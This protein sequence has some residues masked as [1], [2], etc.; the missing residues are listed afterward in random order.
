MLKYGFFDSVK[1]DRKYNVRDIATLFDGIIVDGIYAQI[2][3]RFS[4]N[5][6]TTIENAEDD[7]TVAVGTGQ[8]WLNH[9][10]IINTTPLY[11][12]FDAPNGRFDA[13]VLEVNEKDRNASIFIKK[14][15]ETK[16]GTTTPSIKDNQLTNTDEI[17]QHLLALVHLRSG[18]STITQ[19][20]ITSKIG[21][22][23]PDGIPYVTSP[24]K[25][26]PADETLKQWVAQWS[27][28]YN[29]AIA[30]LET[31]QDDFDTFMTESGEAFTTAQNGRET[32]FNAAQE[33]RSEI[34]SESE[35]S[36]TDIFNTKQTERATAFT[37]QLETQQDDFDTAQNQKQNAFNA[38][39]NTIA[40][41]LISSE[42][43]W[44]TWFENTENAWD[45]WFA[46]VQSSAVTEAY[47]NQI[48]DGKIAE[49][50][51]TAPENLDTI[52]ELAEA[53]Q[54][55]D[56]VLKILNQSIATKATTTY[57]NAQLSTK[58]DNTRFG[59]SQDGLAPAGGS[60]YASFMG[61]G[62]PRFLN[63]DGVYQKIDIVSKY[64]DGLVPK[65]PD[66]DT[67]TKFLRQDGIWDIPGE[68]SY[69]PL[70]GGTLMG[71]LIIGDPNHLD[72][73]TK[74]YALSDYSSS[75]YSQIRLSRNQINYNVVKIFPP[76]SIKKYIT[77]SDNVYLMGT[78]YEAEQ[79]STSEEINYYNVESSG[80]ILN[81]INFSMYEQPKIFLVVTICATIN[82][83]SSLTTDV[84]VYDISYFIPYIN[85]DLNLVKYVRKQVGSNG[86]LRFSYTITNANDDQDGTI[87]L[88][89]NAL[90]YVYSRA[91]ILN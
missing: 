72:N 88:N 89:I 90:T 48:V 70:T 78:A 73:K 65:L 83:S 75:Y 49:L 2:G 57:V 62:I 22:D 25:S 82:A 54:E 79:L 8:A 13:I 68:G 71:S 19:A 46:T 43:D 87:N 26:F 63:V 7:I 33:S 58:A 40:E 67:T 1:G 36:R 81:F 41:W 85:K 66:E 50:V 4:V 91:F 20:D 39:V 3:D 56:D 51:G 74:I 37:E 86:T 55:N 23:F 77:F 27:E 45:V 29:S 9:T 60:A 16:N 44:D 64:K 76:K 10:K 61:D 38:L 52:H 31:Q 47:V 69:L 18:A 32:A 80:I 5:K 59:P 14:N 34:F 21:F 11:L 35:Q 24:L 30:Q 28:F 6:K 53:I 12:T 17:H 42:T 84:S 15:V